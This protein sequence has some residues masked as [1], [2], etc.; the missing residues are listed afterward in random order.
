M[1]MLNLHKSARPAIYQIKS[2]PK[3]TPSQT[4]MLTILDV[5]HYTLKALAKRVKL[6]LKTVENLLSGKTQDPHVTTFHKIFCVYCQVYLK[7]LNMEKI[8]CN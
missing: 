6:P 5:E 1:S 2:K 7:K 4:L 8:S 3:L